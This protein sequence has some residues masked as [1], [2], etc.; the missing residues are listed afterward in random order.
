[1]AQT[2][3]NDE[4]GSPPNRFEGPGI[5]RQNRVSALRARQVRHPINFVC[6]PIGTDG[7][8]AKVY[9]DLHAVEEWIMSRLLVVAIALYGLVSASA[10][11]AAA[12]PPP[13]IFT[14]TGFYVGL[15]GGYAF[16]HESIHPTVLSEAC[17]NPLGCPQ[18]LALLSA[19]QSVSPNSFTGG[20]QVGYNQQFGNVL[21]GLESDI[22]YFRMNGSFAY[23]PTRPSP[24]PITGS[25]TG[26]M[27][28]NWV[29]TLR[30]R[31][32]WV[33]NRLLIYVTGGLAFTDLHNTETALVVVNGQIAGPIGAFDLSSSSNI[34][35][36]VGAGLEYAWTNQW[37][38]KAEY[39]HYDFARVR[40]ATGVMG[41]IGGFDGATMTSNWHLTADTV[42]VGFNF[43]FSSASLP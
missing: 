25:G 3:I 21:F 28:T 15:N 1:L 37:S 33:T 42:R 30:P 13:P 39:L 34:G 38:V 17:D 5:C 26:S 20:L 31:F 29:A 27:S 4:P 10:A 18:I 6:D 40:A 16:G 2:G 9:P 23:G 14:W 8:G 12:P 11:N 22:D 19:G 7:G 41:G 43:K 35:A 32:G 24:Q 36:V